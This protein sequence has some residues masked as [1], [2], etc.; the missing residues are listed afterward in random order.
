MTSSIEK[1]QNT[2]FKKLIWISNS[3]WKLWQLMA[4]S[5]W[6]IDLPSESAVYANQGV[7]THNITQ[8]HYDF[9]L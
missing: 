7:C 2:C 1:I 4:G 5:C 3:P 9:I 6:Q 8:H